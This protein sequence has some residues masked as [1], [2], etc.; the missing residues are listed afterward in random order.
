MRKSYKRGRK[1]V[2]LAM[3]FLGII[4]TIGVVIVLAQSNVGP[5]DT[6]AAG[7]SVTVKEYCVYKSGATVQLSTI[8]IKENG[9]GYGKQCP[10]AKNNSLLS[11]KRITRT[12]PS[13][14]KVV[15]AKYTYWNNGLKVFKVN[16]L[17]SAYNL[18]TPMASATVSFYEF[19]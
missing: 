15:K 4:A 3:F 14:A 10:P 12:S 17:P 18:S 7:I 5:S 8:T 16:P 6:D 2:V 19:K 13:S 1:V 9:V 11:Y